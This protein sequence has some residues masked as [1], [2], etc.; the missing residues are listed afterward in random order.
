MSNFAPK[1]NEEEIMQYSYDR[2]IGVSLLA[3][4]IAIAGVIVLIAQVSFFSKLSD[5]SSLIGVSSYFF[6][7]AVTLLGVLSLATAVGMFLGKKWGWWLALF[8]FAYEI[9][10]NMNAML[11]IPILVE[12][13]GDIS[14]QKITSYYLKSG[15]R[16]A[17][18]GFL[19]FYLCRESVTSYFQT[20]ETK[21]WKVL[22]ILFGVCIAIILISSLLQ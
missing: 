7:A 14:S 19:I 12:Q 21:K 20:T 15:V 5:V 6:Q 18:D 2:P 4:W 10:R 11:S 9:T 16:S 8:Y 13:Y 3:I 17:F 1:S 22:L